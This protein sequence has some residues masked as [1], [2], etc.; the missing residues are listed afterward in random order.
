MAKD[1]HANSDE[2]TDKLYHH[3]AACR[4]IARL[5]K[6]MAETKTML[7]EVQQETQSESQQEENEEEMEQEIEPQ[8]GITDA[9]MEKLKQTGDV[10][11]FFF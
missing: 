9:I 11:F 6:Q 1:I 8:K 7:L 4:I 3:D 10:R 5:T 2:L